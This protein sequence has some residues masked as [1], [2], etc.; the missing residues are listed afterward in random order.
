M[1]DNYW[2]PV[3]LTREAFGQ[4][5]LHEVDRAWEQEIARFVVRTM[6]ELCG[7]NPQLVCRDGS[8]AFDL[9]IAPDFASTAEPGQLRAP[10][11][12]LV[13]L[14]EDGRPSKLFVSRT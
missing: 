11:P 7:P 4:L 1:V 9:T 14:D 10:S 12:R 13:G 6:Y 3:Q 8:Y 5:R 2:G